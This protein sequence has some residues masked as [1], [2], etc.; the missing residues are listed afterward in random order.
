MVKGQLRG[1]LVRFL[2][3]EKRDGSPRRRVQDLFINAIIIPNLHSSK[4]VNVNRQILRNRLSIPVY[5]L[6]DLDLTVFS[7][8]SVKKTYEPAMKC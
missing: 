4:G 7:S 3:G 6:L 5:A 8:G 1:N 2:L